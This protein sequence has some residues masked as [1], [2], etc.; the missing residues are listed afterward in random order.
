MTPR[1]LQTLKAW[2]PLVATV[3]SAGVIWATLQNKVD[4]KVDVIRF[5]LDS[6]ETRRDIIELREAVRELKGDTRLLP[7]ICR[8]VKCK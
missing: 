3:F 1:Q 7:D 8:A 6:V 4:N 5:K 2:A